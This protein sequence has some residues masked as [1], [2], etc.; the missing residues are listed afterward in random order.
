MKISL[1]EARNIEDSEEWELIEETPWEDQGK[2]QCQDVII[3]KDGKYYM[4]TIDRSGSYFSDYYYEYGDDK[5]GMI[6][7]T[8][9]TKRTKTIEYWG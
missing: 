5:D 1:E 7:L 2:Y 6:E 4:F 9:V 8:E 3:K